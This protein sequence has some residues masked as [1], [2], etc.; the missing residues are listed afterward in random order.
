MFENS[1]YIV[2]PRR[3]SDVIALLQVMGIYRYA[4]RKIERWE[5]TIGRVP[6]SANNW[7]QIMTEHPEF[8]RLKGDLASLVWRRSYDKAF[9]PDTGKT[10]SAEELET[11]DALPEEKQPNLTRQA[12]TPDQIT[13]LIDSAIK[14][15]AAAIAYSQELRWRVPILAGILGI[16][17]GAFLNGYRVR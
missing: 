13:A 12:L 7:A 15:H 14:I 8:F 11:I 5:R 10:Y 1:P 3:L 9:D 17:L 6:V 16:L 4:N 2:H